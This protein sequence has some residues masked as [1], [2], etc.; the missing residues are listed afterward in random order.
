MKPMLPPALPTGA[1]LGA[2][3]P[4]LPALPEE[5][6]PAALL[7]ELGAPLPD[8]NPEVAAGLHPTATVSSP[9]RTAD[10]LCAIGIFPNLTGELAPFADNRESQNR[11]LHSV[12]RVPPSRYSLGDR[13]PSAE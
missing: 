11:L 8:E 13:L 5:V 7:P 12:L 4:A 10:V 2:K 3:L 1:P 9:P 6:P